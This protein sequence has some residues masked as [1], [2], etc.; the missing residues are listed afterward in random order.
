MLPDTI[1]TIE[2]SAFWPGHIYPD[3]LERINIPDSVTTIEGAPFLLCKK[4]NV[5]LKVG[6][7]NYITNESYDPTSTIVKTMRVRERCDK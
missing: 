4:V 7:E 2:D 3:N 6:D 5:T 1:T